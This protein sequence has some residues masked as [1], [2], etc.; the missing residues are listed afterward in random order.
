MN[1]RILVYF[2][3]LKSYLMNLYKYL[4]SF[5][6]QILDVRVIESNSK[7]E[8]GVKSVYYKYMIIY[9]FSC[10]KIFIPSCIYD[11]ILDVIDITNH[12]IKLIVYVNGVERHIIYQN[13]RIIHSLNNC[14]VQLDANQNKLNK[15]IE[16][17]NNYI[18]TK[19]IL[20]TP[21]NN[22]IVELD[23]KEIIERYIP[24]D[25]FN[26]TFD[27]VLSFENIYYNILSQISLVIF[28]NG[29]NYNINLKMVDIREKLVDSIYNIDI[30]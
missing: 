20:E 23:I 12:K 1:Q 10:L 18:I 8:K 7:S 14:I 15:S 26:N 21:V 13:T 2:L 9:L 6:Y 3:I 22:Q 5:I 4:F 25:V 17:P 29:K 28:K 19:C 16:L 27:S 30:N 24:C 11:L